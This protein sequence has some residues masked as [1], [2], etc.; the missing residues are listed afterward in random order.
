MLASREHVGNPRSGGQGRQLGDPLVTSY[1]SGN[2]T[3]AA[4][5]TWRTVKK[6]DAHTGEAEGLDYASKKSSSAPIAWS[7]HA[8]LPSRRP[9]DRKAESNER[10]YKM[11]T[12]PHTLTQFG[13]YIPLLVPTN[14]LAHL[15]CTLAHSSPLGTSCNELVKAV[16]QLLIRQCCIGQPKPNQSLKRGKRGKEKKKRAPL[17]RQ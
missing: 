15:L 6:S 12:N 3:H 16:G 2:D 13:H 8:A 10:Q 11:R 9:W 4:T 1:V 7:T 14:S 17:V 5:Q